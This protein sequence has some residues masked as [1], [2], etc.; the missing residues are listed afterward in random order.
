M[1]PMA[2]DW[3]HRWNLQSDIKVLH[4]RI[5]IDQ[6][7]IRNTVS[8]NLATLSVARSI[9]TVFWIPPCSI[10]IIVCNTLISLKRSHLWGYQL[11]AQL[12]RQTIRRRCCHLRLV[13]TDVL[14]RSRRKWCITKFSTMIV[15]ILSL[16]RIHSIISV[17]LPCCNAVY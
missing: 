15:L 5:T 12:S 8:M 3:C 16:R 11:V 10:V 2:P 4:T 1:P 6:G 17:L 13:E 7:G 9:E 14:S